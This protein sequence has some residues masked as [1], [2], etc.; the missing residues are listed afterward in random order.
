MSPEL[1]RISQLSESDPEMVFEELMHHFDKDS[2]RH[3]YSQLSGKAAVGSDG[4]SKAQ[5]G[6]T[7]DD[8]LCDLVDRLKRMGYRPSPVKLVFEVT[9]SQ[10]TVHIF[11]TF[12]WNLYF[13]IY[14]SDFRS[15]WKR[16]MNRYSW[17]VPMV[18]E[19]SVAVTMRLKHWTGTCTV[20]RR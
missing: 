18:S 5:Y 7:L 8:N 2:L 19:R 17:I 1:I 10:G 12:L 20:R 13:F 11:L 15:Y 6:E 3:S 16:F 14:R 4:I 9:Q